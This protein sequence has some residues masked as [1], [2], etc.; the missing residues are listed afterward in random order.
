MT[1]FVNP[2]RTCNTCA[3]VIE[4]KFVDGRTKHGPWAIM[5]MECFETFGV[6]LGTGRGQLYKKMSDGIFRKVAG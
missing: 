3:G 1:T 4:Q 5:C 2:S 6:G